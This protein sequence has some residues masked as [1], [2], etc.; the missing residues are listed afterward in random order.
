MGVSRISSPITSI[1][2]RG[3][4]LQKLRDDKSGVETLFM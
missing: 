2:S 4:E 3:Q 1:E